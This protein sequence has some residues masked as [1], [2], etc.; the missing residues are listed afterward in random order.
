MLEE[1]EALYKNKIQDLLSLPRERKI[2]GNKWVY[3]ITHNGNDQVECFHTRL[4]EKIY[5]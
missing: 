1:I 2:I 4:V 5:D 3:N